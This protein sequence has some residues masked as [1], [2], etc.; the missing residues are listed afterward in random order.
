MARPFSPKRHEDLIGRVE[1]KFVRLAKQTDGQ[2]HTDYLKLSKAAKAV[3]SYIKVGQYGQGVAYMKKHGD[4]LIA[5]L[6]ETFETL[7]NQQ[8]L[9]S[10]KAKSAPK[11]AKA[12]EAA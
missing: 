11:K 5:E 1:R 3:Y 4:A 12:K 2:A 6:P 7:Q 9:K 10:A 8:A